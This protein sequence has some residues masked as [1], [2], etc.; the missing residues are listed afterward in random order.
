MSESDDRNIKRGDL[1]KTDFGV[2]MLNYGT[3]IQRMGYVLREGESSVPHGFQNAFDQ[4]L[5]AR[6][7]I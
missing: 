1:L 7:V 5:K 4:A 2:S 6:A 3:D